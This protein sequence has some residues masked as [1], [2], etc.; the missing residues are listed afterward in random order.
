MKA[1]LNPD[2]RRYLGKVHHKCM[3]ND[4]IGI[5][6]TDAWTADTIRSLKADGSPECLAAA[7]IL[8]AVYGPYHLA[9]T[10]KRVERDEGTMNVDAFREEQK[11]LTG[12][13]K[14]L[15]ANVMVAMPL[16]F[17]P[18]L[19]NLDLDNIK[20][21]N[22]G[23]Q[24]EQVLSLEVLQI[25]ITNI[26]EISAFVT[27]TTAMIEE[28]KD[29]YEKKETQF[30][31]IKKDATNVLELKSAVGE[32]MLKVFGKLTD[33]FSATPAKVMDFFNLEIVTDD[34]R[35]EDFLYVN[36]FALQGYQ[37]TIINADIVL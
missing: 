9:V 8:E 2:Q 37:G 19:K 24:A 18:V 4:D 25:K 36:Q 29:V 34:I 5:L 20:I 23:A 16:T 14:M 17:A 1:K 13:L 28:V 12:K 33:I 31:S 26:P 32:T 22:K 21:Y 10:S 30:K 6:K 35:S 3:N 11:S 15:E 27:S 7:A